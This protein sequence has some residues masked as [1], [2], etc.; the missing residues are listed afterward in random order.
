MLSTI[1]F[2]KTENSTKSTYIHQL[3]ECPYFFPQKKNCYRVLLHN[4]YCMTMLDSI[5]QESR[6]GP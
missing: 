3:L 4:T 5:F 2:F 1:T 6:L